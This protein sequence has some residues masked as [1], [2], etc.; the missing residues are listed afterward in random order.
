MD[1]KISDYI[2]KYNFVVNAMNV[3][4]SKTWQY[5]LLLVKCYNKHAKT[6]IID[7]G[8]TFSIGK[9]IY[10][11]PNLNSDGNIKLKRNF[12]REYLLTK[13]MD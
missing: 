4:N 3:S 9:Q 7:N 6:K 11:I 12:V 5:F 13:S 1:K 2:S 8:S 10:N